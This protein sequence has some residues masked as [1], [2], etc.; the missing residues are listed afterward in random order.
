MFKLN[1][2][3]AYEQ[4]DQS[5]QLPILHSEILTSFLNR[6][7][8]EEEQFILLTDFQDWLKNAK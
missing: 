7:R 3:G 4:I 2:S 1:E 5:D 6:G 8:D